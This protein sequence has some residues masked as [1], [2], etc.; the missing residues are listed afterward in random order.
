MGGFFIT[1]FFKYPCH[2]EEKHRPKRHVN[3]VNIVINSMCDLNFAVFIT[4]QITVLSK[5][6]HR[7]LEELAMRTTA[8]TLVRFFAPIPLF[9]VFSERYSLWP[10]Q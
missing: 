7:S 4:T 10:M 1:W 5:S 6:N 3:T 9:S 8:F 2:T